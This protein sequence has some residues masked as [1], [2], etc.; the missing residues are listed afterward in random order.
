MVIW[1]G[2]GNLSSWLEEHG[3]HRVCGRIL[4]CSVAQVKLFCGLENGGSTVQTVLMRQHVR[5]VEAVAVD[6][7]HLHCQQ[8]RCVARPGS[9]GMCLFRL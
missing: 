9:A 3:P 8:E 6:N 2:S 5:Q 1:I 4:S 7:D